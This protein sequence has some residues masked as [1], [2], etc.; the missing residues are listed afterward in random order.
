M[1]CCVYKVK[2]ITKCGH[3]CPQQQLHTH[4]HINKPKY[5]SDSRNK[6]KLKHEN[7]LSH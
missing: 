5:T 2:F 3:Y 1:F 4:K 6:L 7:M